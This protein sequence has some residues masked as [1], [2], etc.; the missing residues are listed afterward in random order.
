MNFLMIKW[1]L[2]ILGD[3]MIIWLD[4]TYGIGKTTVA[5]Q[6]KKVLQNKNIKFLNSDYLYT[7]IIKRDSLSGG[8]AVPQNNINFLR[9]IRNEIQEE[10]VSTDGILI[11]DMALTQ[12]ESK[13]LLFDYLKNEGIAIKHFILT[14]SINTI[15]KRIENSENRD[16]VLAY[17]YLEQ[18]I[19]FLNSNYDD[20]IRIDTENKNSNEIAKEI[21]KYL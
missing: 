9:V 1:Y 2:L 21:I 4:G 14:A 19:H 7:E 13:E 15:K 11:I 20:A 10:L 3:K 8:G 5:E 16:K 6:L 17:S 18:N 12:K